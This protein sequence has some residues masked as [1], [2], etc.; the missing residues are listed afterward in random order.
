MKKI[1]LSLF[2]AFASLYVQGATST[3]TISGAGTNNLASVP[4]AFTLVSI[5]NS[6]T[7]ALTVA[8]FDTATTALTTTI[9]AYTTYSNYL[10]NVTN[11]YTTSQGVT[12]T[13][14]YQNVVLMATNSV[15]AVTNNVQKLVVF[16]VPA[17]E[18][19]TV[20]FNPPMIAYKG[21]TITNSDACVITGTYTK[22]F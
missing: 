10:G 4:V 16:T 19:L 6:T 18:T 7:N 11:T 5:A 3:L 12:N 17:S 8:L 2:L 22:T 14:V 1:L 15:S 9:G 13:V 21:V 20:P